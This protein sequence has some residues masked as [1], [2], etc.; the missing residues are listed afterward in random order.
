MSVSLRALESRLPPISASHSP[1][2]QGHPCRPAS[3]IK[4]TLCGAVVGAHMIGQRCRDS[5]GP[6]R[7]P[8]VCRWMKFPPASYPFASDDGF[9]TKNQLLGGIGML[10]QFGSRVKQG[11]GDVSQQILERYTGKRGFQQPKREVELSHPRHRQ[12]PNKMVDL[13]DQMQRTKDSLADKE[14]L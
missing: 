13:G 5:R 11:M 12:L 2:S 4:L 6:N 1:T 8:M 7:I 14:T 9:N 3:E 10:P